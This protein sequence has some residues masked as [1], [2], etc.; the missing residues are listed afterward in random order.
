MILTCPNTP[1]DQDGYDTQYAAHVYEWKRSE[2][3]AGLEQSGFEVITEWGILLDKRTLKAEAETLGLLL[4]IERLEKFI[5][6]E[7]LC[8][9]MAPMFPKASKEIAFLCKAV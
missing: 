8:P 4:L 6:S 7:W 1:E 3:L 5:P 2:L 9:V